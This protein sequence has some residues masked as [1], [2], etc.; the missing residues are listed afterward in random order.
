MYSKS[1]L[2]TVALF[3]LAALSANA[4][5]KEPQG[6]HQILARS[7]HL[8]LRQADG[9]YGVCTSICQPLEAKLT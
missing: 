4:A 3:F 8:S 2:S 1:F 7:P 6:P 5:P 9:A